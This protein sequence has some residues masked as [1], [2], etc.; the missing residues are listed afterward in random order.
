[1]KDNQNIFLVTG[2]LGFKLFDEIRNDF[3]DR[4]INAGAAE[5]AMMGIAVGLAMENKIP[6]CYSI[7]PFLL[8][9]TAETIRNYVN[10]EKVAVRLVGSGRG[11]DYAHDGFSHDA[12]D[13]VD[14]LSCFRNIKVYFPETESMIESIVDNMVRSNEATYINLKR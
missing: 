10:H 6:F 2:D 8:W 3:P 9:R 5:V 7:T 11:K 1:M 13:D 14:I 4:V 12:S